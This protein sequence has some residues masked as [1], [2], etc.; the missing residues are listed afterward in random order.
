MFIWSCAIYRFYK[1]HAHTNTRACPLCS[2]HQAKTGQQKLAQNVSQTTITA[3]TLKNKIPT[4][5]YAAEQD[6]SS[7]EAK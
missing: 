4:T 6:P 1:T 5:T 2:L 3:Y 7:P